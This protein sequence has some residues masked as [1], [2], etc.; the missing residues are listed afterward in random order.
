VNAEDKNHH[1]LIIDDNRAIHDDFRKI[2]M[3]RDT[4]GLDQIKAKLFGQAAAADRPRKYILDSAFQGQ[5][6]LELV[7]A[8]IKT[9][10][11]YALAFIDMRM[12]PGWDGLQTIEK[13]WEVDPDIQI[14]I[15]TAHSDYSW[16]DISNKFGSRDHLLILKK[17]FDIV[18]V[19]QLASALTEKWHLARHAHLKLNQLNSMVQERTRELEMTN[20]K[21]L[22]EIQQRKE[23]EERY[24]LAEIGVNDGLWDWDL[25]AD[26]IYYSPRW[27]SMLGY[28]DE[29]IGDSPQEWFGRIFKDDLPRL[30]TDQKVH[31]EGGSEQWRGEYRILHK[32]G[33]FRWI[34]CRGVSVRGPDNRAV[35]AAGSFTDITD[36][37]M[38]ENQLRFEALHDGLT[39]LANRNRLMDRISHC[40]ARAHRNPESRFA[41]LFMDLDR[42]KVINDSLGHPMGDKVLVEIGKRLTVLIRKNDTFARPGKNHLA[43]IGGDEFVLLLEDIRGEAD[44]LR[45]AERMQQALVAPF[46]IDGHEICTIVSIGVALGRP[47]YQRAE[48]ILRD[49][50]T[51]M[52]QAKTAGKACIRI[53]NPE[54]H[55]SAMKLWQIETELRHAIENQEL[56]LHYQPIF[57]AQGRLVSLEALIRWQHPVRGL[58][59]P[60]EFIPIAEETGL[61][62][63]IGDWVMLTACLQ[64]REW[65]R[66]F[67]QLAALCVGVNV[68]G[69]QFALSSFT[70]DVAKVLAQSGLPASCLRL[71]ITESVAMQNAEFAIRTL[72]RLHSLGVKIDVDD[73]GTGYSSLSYLHSMPIDTLKIDRSFIGLME[74]DMMSCS[75]IQAIMALAHSL[76]LDVVAEGVENEHHLTSLRKMGCDF[77]QGYYLSRPLP[78]EQATQ[79]IS[80]SAH[81][82]PAAKNPSEDS[83]TPSPIVG[84]IKPGTTFKDA[85][86]MGA[87]V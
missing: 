82:L 34:L 30:L 16:E 23:S 76:N 41:V 61:I 70:D 33:Q 65:Q 37:K 21:L 7:R 63:Q 22:E 64:L 81:Q 14:V 46:I 5:E 72:V 87:V 42:F 38:A 26:K 53:F 9:G 25:A 45:V 85:A 10:N 60:G 17:P 59:P 83:P 43:R 44:A 86:S 68:S 18:E 48:D 55:A 77:V 49:A 54:M 51:A 13:L 52:Y 71:E 67:P 50:D 19:C 24:R 73:F 4:G 35:R 84:T 66:Q 58:V 32:D 75:I 2:L 57:S 40:L 8:S 29:E 28:D 56:L 1:I 80:A 15:C 39:G 3:P 12:P 11:R 27:K 47:N 74:R 62:V 20:Q 36:R 69:K 31:F 79:F 78:P 6:G